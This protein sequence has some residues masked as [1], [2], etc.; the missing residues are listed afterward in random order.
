M[1][2]AELWRWG[3]PP[4]EIAQLL[5]A[6]ERA[7]EWIMG[8]GDRDGDGFVE[9]DDRVL[10]G[11]SRLKNQGWKDS[12]DAIRHPDGSLA[13]GPIALVEVQAYCVAALRG[14]AELR[15]GFGTGDPDPLRA[16]ADQLAS[17]I[18]DHF[19]IEEE[20][21]YGLALDGHKQLV[22][23]VS[24]NPGHVLWAGAARSDR[25]QRLAGRL[26]ADDMFNGHG[27]RTSSSTNGGYNPLSYHCG[28]V[29]PHDTSLAAAGMYHYGQVEMANRL[30][31]SL[32]ATASRLD[33]CLPE[34][35][36]GLSISRYETPVPYPTSCSPQAWASGAPLLLLRAMLGIQPN[37]PSGCV[38]LRPMLPEGLEIEL[39]GM[40]LGRGRLS[41]RARGRAVEVLEA[42]NGLDIEIDVPVLRR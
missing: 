20:S 7:V 21:C 25:A 2:L 39:D 14:L 28:T 27:L 8:P 22:A 35:F 1:A 17:A 32:L 11:A 40:P 23:S 38:Q 29:W 34:L 13:Q 19:W 10:P 24:S 41:L 5:P 42:P 16:R 3:A 6:A 18:E 33:N 9:Y 31:M 4:L 12:D 15:Q 37:V 30:S 36:G 26:M